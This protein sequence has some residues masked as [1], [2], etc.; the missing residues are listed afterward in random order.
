MKFILQWI[1][2]SQAN[3]SLLH[4]HAFD[5]QSGLASKIQTFVE[6]ISNF[7]K[8]TGKQ[9]H[10]SELYK[11]FAEKNSIISETNDFSCLDEILFK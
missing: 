10:V 11:A 9:I 2:A 5:D 6:K 7:S 8:K 1:S 3:V 4:Y